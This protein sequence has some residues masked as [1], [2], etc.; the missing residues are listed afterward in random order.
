MTSGMAKV[1]GNG[2]KHNSLVCEAFH[3]W[4]RH[5]FGW[6]TIGCETSGWEILDCG[7]SGLETLF[8]E[9]FEHPL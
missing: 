8:S 4:V 2:P 6:E 9:V 1:T 5:T 7:I 3:T